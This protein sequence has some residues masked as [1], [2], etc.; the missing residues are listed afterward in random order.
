MDLAQLYSIIY[1]FILLMFF[2]VGILLFYF[3]AA[4]LRMLIGGFRHPA[5][6]SKKLDTIKANKLVGLA[7]SGAGAFTVLAGVILFPVLENAFSDL[8]PEIITMSARLAAACGI[9][10]VLLGLSKAL[11]YRVDLY[12]DSIVIFN[13][14]KYRVIYADELEYIY[15]N[16]KKCTIISRS[17][18][19]VT[20]SKDIFKDLQNKLRNY[21][22]LIN[23]PDI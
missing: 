23:I 6:K 16:D 12:T 22:K 13:D 1:V 15:W 5:E 11:L 21:Q 14:M 7:I 3:F 17:A 20:L 10:L 18:R 4:A 19:P 2:A 9:L 8:P